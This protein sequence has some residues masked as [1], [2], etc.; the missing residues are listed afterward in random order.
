VTYEFAGVFP[1]LAYEARK[2][3]HENQGQQPY[4]KLTINDRVAHLLRNECR[5]QATDQMY[6]SFMGV[7]VVV[8]PLCEL[9]YFEDA[10]GRRTYV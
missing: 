5:Y 9:P 2:A 1:L 10:Q 3:A 7:K 6:S 8:D 4:T